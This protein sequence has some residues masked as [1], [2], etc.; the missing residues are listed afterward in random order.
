MQQVRIAEQAKLSE[1]LISNFHACYRNLR[2]LARECA[3]KTLADS[4]AYELAKEEA[5]VE[6][7]DAIFR[8]AEQIARK[9]QASQK[10]KPGRRSPPGNITRDD[11]KAAIRAHK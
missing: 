8:I 10:G 7:Q 5:A 2:G 3:G 6:Q 11:M 4:A 9:R 1:A